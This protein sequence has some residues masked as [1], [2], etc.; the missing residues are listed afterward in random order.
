M[1]TVSHFR[2]KQHNIVLQLPGLS[3]ETHMG[4]EASLM[5]IWDLLITEDM[6]NVMI[7]WTNVK[8]RKK[9]NKYKDAPY[10]QDVDLVEMNAFIGFLV[11]I[12]TFKSTHE[13]FRSVFASD[14]TGRGIFPCLMAK[15]RFAF[16]LSCLRF[17]S[18]DIR[19]H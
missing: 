11:Y 3:R 9:R 14:Y 16:L 2:P 10:V 4:D 13:D 19:E 12:D 6:L 1:V 7:M 18:L 8:I 17:D 15:N 5:K